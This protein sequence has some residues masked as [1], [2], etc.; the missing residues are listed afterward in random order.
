MANVHFYFQLFE[1]FYIDIYIAH[2]GRY[3]SSIKRADIEAPATA[4][5]KYKALFPMV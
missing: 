1:H 3:F 4:A 5:T 2:A